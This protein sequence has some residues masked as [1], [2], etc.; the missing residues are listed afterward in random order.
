MERKK[1]FG[2]YMNRNHSWFVIVSTGEMVKPTNM[3][4][5]LNLKSL[6]SFWILCMFLQS[7]R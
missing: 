4:W 3:K 2:G 7:T 5:N 6:L 1:T